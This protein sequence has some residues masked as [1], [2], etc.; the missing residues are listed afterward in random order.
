MY[1]FDLER[2]SDPMN[3]K[4]SKKLGYCGADIV[5]KLTGHIP[6]N[7]S[8]KL[9]FDKYFTY[10]ELLIELKSKNIW[11]VGTLRGDSMRG[12]MLKSEKHLKKDGR[13]SYDGAVKKNSMIRIV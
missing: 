6:N 8:Y 10:I 5:L 4:M 7:K 2:A 12:C 9:Y 1:D 3:P 13:G 11:A